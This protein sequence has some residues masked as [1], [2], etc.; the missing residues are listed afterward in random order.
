M[1]GLLGIDIDNLSISMFACQVDVNLDL[2]RATDV[3]I[4]A[5]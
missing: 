2:L 3:E 4:N 5:P 1:P